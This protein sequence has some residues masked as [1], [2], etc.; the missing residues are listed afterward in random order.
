MSKFLDK[1]RGCHWRRLLLGG[2]VSWTQLNFDLASDDDSR[3]VSSKDGVRWHG[4]G[5]IVK[6]RGGC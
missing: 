3:E 5:L 2:I 6:L 1:R 4:A